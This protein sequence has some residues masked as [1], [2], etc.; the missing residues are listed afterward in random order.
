MPTGVTAPKPVITISS[1]FGVTSRSRAVA[2]V[3]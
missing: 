2:Y 3:E 1:L